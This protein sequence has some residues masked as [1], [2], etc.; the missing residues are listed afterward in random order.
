MRQ[1]KTRILANC[2]DFDEKLDY[3]EQ[4]TTGDANKIVNGYSYLKPETG[5]NTALKELE[6]RYGD[7]NIIVNAFVT[8]AL[9]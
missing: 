7:P 6:D 2:D 8:K 5:Y 9:S 1:F 3:L 4:Y